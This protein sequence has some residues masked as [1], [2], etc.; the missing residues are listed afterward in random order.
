MKQKT[1]PFQKFMKL[2]WNSEQHLVPEIIS[3]IHVN[4]VDV[5]DPE[6]NQ[7]LLLPFSAHDV[8]GHMGIKMQF[9]GKTCYFTVVGR[10]LQTLILSEGGNHAV[11]KRAVD[12]HKGRESEEGD[13]SDFPIGFFQCIGDGKGIHVLDAFLL[14]EDGYDD[15]RILPFAVFV[16]VAVLSAS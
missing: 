15:F 4:A 14:D 7:S 6:K 3:V 2:H 13:I 16:H 10:F 8:T 1:R 5:D 12:E 11:E 9:I